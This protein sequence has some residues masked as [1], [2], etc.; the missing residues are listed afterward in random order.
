MPQLKVISTPERHLIHTNKVYLSPE[1]LTEGT[2]VE[3][4][5]RYF[6]AAHHPMVD[7]DSIGLNQ[8]Q[9][10]SVGVREQERVDIHETQPT[11][12]PKLAYVEIECNFVSPSVV[13]SN[14]IDASTLVRKIKDRYGGHIVSLRQK[15]V[16]YLGTDNII[17]RVVGSSENSGMLDEDTIL[18]LTAIDPMVLEGQQVPIFNQKWTFEQ[19]GIGGLDVELNSLF[20]RAFASRIFSQDTMNRMGIKHVKGIILHGPPGTGKTLI[21]RQIGKILQCEEPKVV[22]GPEILNKYVG[23]SEENIRLLFVDAEQQ[24]DKLHLV[25]F[26]EIDAICKQRGTTSG[27]TGVGD[28]IVNQLLTKMDGINSLDNVLVIGMTN[29]LDMLDEALLRPG[30]FEVQ[31]EIGLPN[32]EGRCQ[33]LKIHTEK[34]RSNS[35]LED[36]SLDIL[37]SKTQNY[38]GAELEGL[39][40][41]ATSFALN[42]V[43]PDLEVRE[44]INVEDIKV[45]QQDFDN[46][47]CEVK[48]KF[49]ISGELGIYLDC[50]LHDHYSNILCSM[51]KI[52]S[53]GAPILVSGDTGVGKTTLAVQC[54]QFAAQQGV[55]YIKMVTA[56]DFIGYS[57]QSICLKIQKIFDDALRCEKSLI[58]LDDIASL[59]QYSS[60]GMR[61]SN[62]ILQTLL[63]LIKRRIPTEKKLTIIGTLSLDDTL[64]RLGI[65]DAFR[66]KLHVPLLSVEQSQDILSK[67][68]SQISID[69]P[70]ST[71]RVLSLIELEKLGEL[72]T[73]NV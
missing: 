15:I 21:A 38:S 10:Q 39:V 6:I 26:D 61:Y 18:H 47:L 55:S 40:R 60:V 29:R 62:Q 9:R 12:Y 11:M 24:P 14:R 72:D 7:R 67:H 27:S 51:N 63:T 37:A 50:D 4:N 34:L 64:R 70:I 71:Q 57:E 65:V 42:R 32:E 3:I 68:N 20:R 30:R 31:I 5:G 35:Y 2:Y 13:E 33:I 1:T 17:L 44:N 16:T 22:N 43:I 46:A 56:T 19:L 73:F 45:T 28:S 8:L 53:L 25:I 59:I 69:E 54:S 66:V 49:G 52:A 36:V 48:P 41:S 23:Q 58:I